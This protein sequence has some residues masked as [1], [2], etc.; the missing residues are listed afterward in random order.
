MQV[1][2]LDKSV[3]FLYAYS[4]RFVKVFAGVGHATGSPQTLS[5]GSCRHVNKSQFLV[6]RREKEKLY[7]M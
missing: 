7:K 3:W 6:K 1:F 4:L 2:E 5:Q